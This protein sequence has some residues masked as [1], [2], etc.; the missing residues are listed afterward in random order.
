[1]FGI[2]KK[3]FFIDTLITTEINLFSNQRERFRCKISSLL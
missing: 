1:M 2:K 3:F